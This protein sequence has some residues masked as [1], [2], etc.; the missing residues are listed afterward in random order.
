M[1]GRNPSATSGDMRKAKELIIGYNVGAGLDIPA[2]VWVKG[3]H[4][5]TVL[6]GGAYHIMA[7]AGTGNT[8]KTSFAH[9]MMLQMSARY[10]SGDQ[11]VLDTE[12]IYDSVR[13]D[14]ISKNMWEWTGIRPSYLDD[15]ERVGVER[16]HILDGTMDL[17]DIYTKLKDHTYDTKMKA[18]KSVIGTTPF[19]GKDGQPMKMLYPTQFGLDAISSVRINAQDVMMEK[20]D[21]GDSKTNT[22]DLTGGRVKAQFLSDIIPLTAKGNICMFITAHIGDKFD[23]SGRGMLSKDMAFMAPDEKLKRCPDQLKYFANILYQFKKCAPLYDPSGGKTPMYPIG[24]NDRFRENT[25]LMELYGIAVRS[26][27]GVSGIPFRMV[28]SQTNGIQGPLTEFHQINY[29]E[30]I[31]KYGIGDPN[32]TSNFMEL[33]PD[34]KFMRTTIREQLNTDHALRNAVT[35]TLELLQMKTLWH[36]ER[37]EKLVDPKELYEGIQ[38]RGYDLPELL[39]KTHTFWVHDEDNCPWYELTTMDLINMYHGTYHPYWLEDDKKTIKPEWKKRKDADMED[40]ELL[41]QDIA[42]YIADHG[43]AA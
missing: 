42:K 10:N 15:A 2:G 37:V 40:R 39:S 9:Y 20:H 26:K 35:H 41:K 18:G 30:V 14:Q 16:I 5:N 38:K 21:V 25:D 12:L 17:G 1:R 23:M 34:T 24:K 6:S 19:L 28:G 11:M 36:D 27:R 32:K 31:K 22:Y 4:G 29:H 13:Q 7:V 8:F 43:A 3:K 33:L